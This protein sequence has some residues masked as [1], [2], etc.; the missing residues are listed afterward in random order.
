MYC[1]NDEIKTASIYK[2]DDTG[3]FGRHFIKVNAPKGISPKLISKCEFQCGSYYHIVE[4]PEF[5]YYIDPKAEDTAKLDKENY[6]YLRVYDAQGNK[7]TLEGT[8]RIIGKKQVVFG[9]QTKDSEKPICQCETSNQSRN[10]GRVR[11]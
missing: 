3:A 7:I 9:N 10:N 2:N 5:P 1:D 4:N 6:C 11:F 8:M